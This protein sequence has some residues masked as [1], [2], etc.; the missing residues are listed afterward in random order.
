MSLHSPLKFKKFSLT[1]KSLIQP[2][3]DQYKPVSCEYNFTNLYVWQDAAALSWLEYKN[4]ILIHDG[5]KGFETCFMPLGKEFTPDELAALSKKLIFQ[6]LSP[7][8][9][10]VWDDYLNT[11]PDIEKFYRITPSR[12][13]AEYI[14]EVEALVGLRGRKL[15]KKKNLISQ[16]K[17]HCPDYTVEKLDAASLNDVMLFLDQQKKKSKDRSQTQQQEDDAIKKAIRHFSDLDM[18]GL[19]LIHGGQVIGFAAFTRHT[20]ST[21]IVH[22]EKADRSLKGIYQ[23]LNHETAKYLRG[24]CRFVN[25]EQ[26]LG[27]TGLRQAKK[28]Y[29][30]FE[31]K[32]PNT[33]VFNC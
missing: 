3:V 33:L 13:S 17:N 12:D 15:Q 31:I 19:V 28:S 2:F 32:V 20:P 9:S 29:E 14:Y 25:R 22:F 26:D 5:E 21:Y 23:V 18:E 30:P 24:R 7:D 4:R 10:L 8:I 1:D 16:F 27:I 6:G 11:Y